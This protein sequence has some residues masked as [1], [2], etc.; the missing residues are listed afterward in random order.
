MAIRQLKIIC[1][2][3]KM[4][5][6]GNVWVSLLFTLI[7]LALGVVVIY[8]AMKQYKLHTGRDIT[9]D[10]ILG[11][12][13]MF[14]TTGDGCTGQIAEGAESIKRNQRFNDTEYGNGMVCFTEDG[15]LKKSQSGDV[16]LSTSANE[17]TI[18]QYADFVND[19]KL[20]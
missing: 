12:E 6:V 2:L 5:A 20:F 18:E 15:V 1:R 17:F 4:G 9:W 16:L 13:S 7:K 19:G 14:E 11:N 3:Y 8:L 10:M